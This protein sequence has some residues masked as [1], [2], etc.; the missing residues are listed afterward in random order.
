MYRYQTSHSF[1]LVGRAHHIRILLK[2]WTAQWGSETLV[3]EFIAGKR[4]GVVYPS[5]AAQIRKHD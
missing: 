4:N 2:Q 1:H 5:H 3:S